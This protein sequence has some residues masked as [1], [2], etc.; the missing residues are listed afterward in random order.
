VSD[1]TDAPLGLSFRPERLLRGVRDFGLSVTRL[2]SPRFR[3]SPACRCLP[4]TVGRCRC[5][6]PPRHCKPS[7]I[8]SGDHVSPTIVEERTI[9]CRRQRPGF[10]LSGPGET[11]AESL[12]ANNLA[13]LS[14]CVR[15][16]RCT[17][18]VV[19]SAG[20]SIKGRERLWSLR[21]PVSVSAIPK[22]TCM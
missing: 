2:A 20:T 8:Q 4:W 17:V 10:R 18:R 19:F 12:N 9:D 22:F 6:K 1:T 15:H 14:Q 5:R 21:N 11:G 3:N 13:F 7:Y 16:H